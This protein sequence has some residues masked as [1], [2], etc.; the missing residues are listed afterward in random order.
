MNCPSTDDVV[1]AVLPPSRPHNGRSKS[2]FK[3]ALLLVAL[4]I[5]LGPAG[6]STCTQQAAEKHLAGAAKTSFLEKCWREAP[7]CNAQATDKK[8]AGAAKTSFL[9]KC[10]KDSA[11]DCEAHA[12]EKK[13]HGAAK[14]SFVGKCVKDAVGQ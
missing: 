7:T 6:A 9:G 11:A 1:A 14:T 12:A 5:P 2:M 3:S 8:L 13:L 4:L 10:E